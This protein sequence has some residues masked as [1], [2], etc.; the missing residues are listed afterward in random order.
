M[1]TT[2]T[3]IP[4]HEHAIRHELEQ[5]KAVIRGEHFVYKSG[6]H[7]DTYVDCD[8][9]F[10]RPLSLLPVFE[11][12][13]TRW[14]EGVATDQKP[15]VVIAP[16]VGGVYLVS[17]FALYLRYWT[18]KT[19][20]A[21][22]DRDDF[23]LERAGFAEAV[24]GRRVLVLE[25]VITTGGSAVKTA[26]VARTAG[27]DVVGIA[28]IVNRSRATTA[29]ALGVPCFTAGV[30]LDVPSFAPDELPDELTARPIVTNL[31]HGATFRQENP[32]YAGD[33]KELVLDV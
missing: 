2:E 8:R 17:A 27:G 33:F 11:Y 18:L 16:A 5:S 7:G 10:V 31:A 22:K 13:R 3:A 9:L 25:D 21:D 6:R 1:T 26:D 24:R 15:E 30:Q 20:W 23:V 12:W 4:R 29:K 28:C 32:N 14:F 19:V